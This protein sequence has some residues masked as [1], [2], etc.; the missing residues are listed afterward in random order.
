MKGRPGELLKAAN[1]EADSF[2]N[3]AQQARVHG[4]KV[5]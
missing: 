3:N 4:N 2:F 5:R 1:Q